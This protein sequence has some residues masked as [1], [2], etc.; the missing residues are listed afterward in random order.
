MAL[1]PSSSA[2]GA[3]QVKAEEEIVMLLL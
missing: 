1:A 2:S 3:S